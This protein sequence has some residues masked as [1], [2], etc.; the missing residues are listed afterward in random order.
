MFWAAMKTLTPQE[1][2]PFFLTSPPAQEAIPPYRK[3]TVGAAERQLRP[4]QTCR[5]VDVL[6]RASR[7]RHT[8]SV[9]DYTKKIKQAIAGQGHGAA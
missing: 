2:A 4:D 9:E 8:R 7:C 6:R 5:G 1:W 3:S